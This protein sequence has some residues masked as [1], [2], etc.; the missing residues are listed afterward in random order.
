METVKPAAAAG[1]GATGQ[2]WS[3]TWRSLGRPRRRYRRLRDLRP[4]G[5]PTL[6]A[7]PAGVAATA[8][9]APA[10]FPSTVPAT[11]R[12]SR[13]GTPKASSM[14]RRGAPS[15]ACEGRSQAHLG[16]LPVTWGRLERFPRQAPERMPPTSTVFPCVGEGRPGGCDAPTARAPVPVEGMAPRRGTGGMVQV[17]VRTRDGAATSGGATAMAFA[18]LTPQSRVGLAGKKVSYPQPRIRQTTF[19][20]VSSPAATCGRTSGMSSRET[21]SRAIQSVGGTNPR[22]R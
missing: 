21:T 11:R 9:T 7:P 8:P 10:W 22:T 20:P 15:L 14:P 17:G 4:G 5:A 16:R 6:S 3:K 19:L 2:P 1:G 18:V 12:S 13:T